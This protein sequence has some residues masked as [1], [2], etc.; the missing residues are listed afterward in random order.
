MEVQVLSSA[1]LFFVSRSLLVAFLVAAGPGPV[2]LPMTL[3][4]GETVRKFLPATMPG[5]VAVFD[6]DND[7]QLDLYFPNGAPLP[8]GRKTLPAHANRFF[9]NRGA[10]RFEDRTTASG[11]SGTGYDFAAAAGDF[12][13]D[14]QVDLLVSGL[15]GVTLYRNRGQGVFED[16]TARSKLDN[17]GRWSVGAAWLDID[18]DGDLD[19]FV[20]NYVQW[21][22]ATEK[23]CLVDGQPDFCHPRAYQ[24]QPN[25]LFRN[26]GDGT[27]TDISASSGIAQHPGKGMAAAVAD[28]DLDGRLD[29]FV[30]NDRVFNFL[31]R[32]L[33]DGRFEEVAFARGVAA[34]ANGN[35]PS[36]MGA[37]A[38]DFDN[39]GR[40]DLVYTALRDET[41]P[42]Y[43]NA[44]AEF[45]EATVSSRLSVLTRAMAGWGIVFADLD[46]DGWKDLAVARGEVLS[47]TGSKGA[48]AREPLS[49][50]RN[51]EGRH[52][53]AGDAIPAT[54]Q[55][56]RGLAVAD[57]DNDGCLDLVATALQ[58]APQVIKRACP[59][60]SHWLEVSVSAGA[61]VQVGP[62]W[63]HATYTSGY[64]SSCNCPLHF[65]VSAGTVNV[66]V[67]W[68]DGK[69][70]TLSDVPVDRRIAVEP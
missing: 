15:R 50:L 53:V 30:T 37:D 22:P 46:N 34:P 35:P 65:G 31:F 10:M 3:F 11:L 4:T 5:G 13:R 70:K 39:D 64:A 60:A 1:P 44:G 48:L 42:L 19:L 38:Q 21:D 26:E 47:A 25:A 55:L 43:R 2:S 14:G 29:I 20:V 52:F 69:Q 63:R 58:A 59:P 40:P 23:P 16:V 49:W 54:N 33:G 8:G 24:P 68:P 36:A 18:N 12:D 57:L 62:Q 17:H 56:Y 9:R 7:G 27:F 32:N 61:R 45:V 51:I 6:A 66:K 67:T 28:F 41:F